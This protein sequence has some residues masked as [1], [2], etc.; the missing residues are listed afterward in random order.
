MPIYLRF[1]S[2]NLVLLFAVIAFIAIGTSL[3]FS[4]EKSKTF[5]HKEIIA[6][7]EEANTN[8]TKV[9][10]NEL[11]PDINHIIDLSEQTSNRTISEDE[12]NFV[13]QKIRKFIQG[14]GV[15]KVHIFNQNGIVVY[16]TQPSK[17][18][19]DYSQQP[20]F[21]SAINGKA[22]SQHSFRDN[23]VS[24]NGKLLKRDLVSSYIPIFID[25]K[26]QSVAE[27]YSDRSNAIQRSKELNQSLLLS[28][29]PISILVF[30]IL[31]SVV[32]YLDKKRQQQNL[33]LDETNHAL[34]ESIQ[35]EID[36]N[37]AKS[38]FLAVMSH[39]IRTPLNGVIA[40]LSLINLNELSDENKELVDT[41]MNS[42]ELLTSVINDILDY[43][44]IQANKFELNPKPIDVNTFL[45]QVDK[46]YRSQIE[47]K[48]LKFHLE[49]NLD[50]DWYFEGDPIR[51]KQIINNYLNNAYKFTES[52]KI[53][54]SSK[55]N[56][57]E[58]LL[59]ICD[60]GVGISQKA[61]NKL[62]NEFSQV[63]A[64]T[65]RSHGGTGL[66]LAIS[67][68]LAQ[69]MNGEVGVDSDV[70][71][72]SCFWV[73]VVLKKIDPP[74]IENTD[75]QNENYLVHLNK[76]LT[77]LIVEDNQ[78]NQLIAQKLLKASGFN[79]KTVENGQE[80]L[81]FFEKE[82]HADLI[83]MDC[84]M[85]ILDGFAATKVLRQR[86]VN[87]PI[88][89]LTAN[90]QKS[91]QEKCLAVGMNDFLSKPFK[92]EQFDEVIRRNLRS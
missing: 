14:T 79:Y 43:S 30:L 63:D 32:W 60:T 76:D 40:T 36:A 6:F 84:Q 3:Y 4:L 57:N 51:I 2:K 53:T 41:A 71:K 55:V 70:G 87:T 1:I 52:G 64:G 92:K 80:C 38:S 10:V 5:L 7:S 88:I 11:Y 12:F 78:V 42:S 16:S 83:L 8:I 18:G 46:S 28:L 82:Q 50:Q 21:Q 24:M 54:L 17:V 35:R 47:N 19:T 75:D 26:I 9:F 56:G 22:N 39:E 72:G 13:D 15:L 91:D 74:V 33:Q 45:N 27:V 68:K 48:G 86:A 61:Q 89:A 85:P 49:T 37:N 65:T 69:L 66:G 90:A 58:W 59:S 67:K 73:K 31:L 34:Q 20:G 81:E 77:I 29:A 25:N 23:F 44:K 62:F